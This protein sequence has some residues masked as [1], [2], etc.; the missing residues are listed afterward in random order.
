MAVVK[1]YQGYQPMRVAVDSSRV[2]DGGSLRRGLWLVKRNLEKCDG[3]DG[4]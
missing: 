4:I 1:M 2:N 3:P